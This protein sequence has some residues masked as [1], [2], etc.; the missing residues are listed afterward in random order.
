MFRGEIQDLNG[1]PL[2]DTRQQLHL[3]GYPSKGPANAKVVLVE[4]ADF[5]CPVCRQLDQG[6]RELLVKYPQVRLVFKDFPIEQIHPWARTAATWP[7]SWPSQEVASAFTTPSTAAA[8]AVPMKTSAPPIT[9]VANAS[10]R[11]VPPMVGTMVMVGAYSPP[12]RPARA[13]PRPKVRL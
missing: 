6:L 9:T 3:E 10:I 7:I 11:K 1:D 2:A 8:G 12:V 13:A 5:E 4:F